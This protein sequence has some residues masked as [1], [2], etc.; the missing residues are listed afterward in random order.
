MLEGNV[1]NKQ[2]SPYDVAEHLRSP[3][4]MALYLQACIEESNG[5]VEFIV[6]AID[7]I[8]RSRVINQ[9]PNGP[10]CTGM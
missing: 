3:H 2:T 4:E 6:K 5:D 9:N 7:D 10:E 1:K 8:F